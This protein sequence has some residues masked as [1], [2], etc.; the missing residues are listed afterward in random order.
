[1]RYLPVLFACLPAAVWAED[2]PLQSHV[3]DV[4]LYPQ[5]ATIT[6]EVT[7][8]A[9]AGQHQLILTD[10]PRATPLERV[11]VQIEGATMGSVTARRDF[12]PP[13]DPQ[14]SAA[15][16]AAEAEVERAKEAVT[17]E[18]AEIRLIRLEAQA[19]SARVAFLEE[20]GAGEDVA[21]LGVEALRDLTGMIGAETLKALRVAHE[22]EGR[23]TARLKSLKELQE[24]VARAQ[25]ALKALTAGQAEDR[26]MLAVDITAAAAS[27]ARAVITYT[28]E[29]AGWV[30]VYDLKLTRDTGVL[31]IERGA[32]VSQYS[33]ENWQDVALT[34]STVRPS[35]QSAPGEVWPWLRRIYDPAEQSQKSVS[36]VQLEADSLGGAMVGSA[37]EA[38]VMVE[39]AAASFDGLSVTYTYPGT[40]NVANQADRVRVALGTL[41]T[42][43]DLTAEASP[44]SDQTAFLMASLTNDMGELILPTWEAMFYM[45]GRFVGQ[46]ALELIPSGGEAE[47]SFGPIE[48]LRLTRAIVDRNE[49]DRG[50]I[51]KSNEVSEHARITIENL[52][53]E[54]WPIRLLD[55]VPYS[56]QEDL[57]ITWEADMT[58]SEKDVDDKRGVLAWEFDLPAG[59][60][61]TINL[62]HEIEWPEGQ[63]LQ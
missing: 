59:D 6:R 31:Q 57:R 11:R 23:A 34:L 26:A 63:N 25:Q 27:E 42:K 53:G 43:V 30:P 46:R 48:G 41:E 50:V 52:T 14:K 20:L 9:P 40:I 17:G 10:L 28:I 8:S 21:S 1:M 33:G 13:V 7:F 49:G 51:R 15:I 45:D 61:K 56:E 47:L 44:L 24:D 2:I 37:M 39:Q 58:P 3:S 55:R 5:G 12:V 22:A 29:D 16:E 38:P 4:T 60:S 19:A 36:R 18:E 32:F 54:T 62:V 35:E